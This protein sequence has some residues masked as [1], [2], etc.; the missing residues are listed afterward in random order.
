MTLTPRF[1][2]ITKRNG[3]AT[4][5]SVAIDF[6][7][8]LAQSGCASALPHSKNTRK[9]VQLSWEQIYESDPDVVIVGCCGF[10]LK[11]NEADAKTAVERL[12]PLRAFREGRIYAAD[13]NLYFARPGPGLREGMAILARC[14]YDGED[15]HGDA[16]AG[17]YRQWR[18]HYANLSRGS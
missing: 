8:K 5:G 11:R 9:S 4:N 10:D 6:E 1:V 14:A 18:I 12:R 13:G 7:Q 3:A 17:A 2:V 16:G 15:G